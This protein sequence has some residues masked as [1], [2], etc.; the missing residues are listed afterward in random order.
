M[1]NEKMVFIFSIRYVSKYGSEAVCNSACLDSNED[2]AAKS[3]FAYHMRNYKDSAVEKLRYI[4][5]MTLDE[6]RDL[7]LNEVYGDFK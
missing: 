7:K 5:K 2:S 4:C 6:Y 1:S 3:A